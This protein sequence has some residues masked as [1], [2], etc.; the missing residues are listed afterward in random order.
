M[1]LFSLPR[2]SA[3]VL[4]AALS[5]SALAVAG[6]ASATTPTMTATE[7]SWSA[8]IGGMINSERHAHGV[9]NVSMSSALQCSAFGHDLDMAKYNSMSHQLPGEPVFTT[10]MVNCG[11]TGWHYAGENIAWNSDMSLAGLEY[12]QKEMYD[13][14][15]PDNGH[16]L[17]ILNSHF[18]NV[19]VSVYLDT[20]NHKV[21]LTEDFGAK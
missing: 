8:T 21:W 3:L 1:R 5:I 14:V 17:N 4:T 2:L 16:R 20:K 10:R 13:E 9:A 6:P 7:K 19:G 15:A 12:L 11:Y 18:V